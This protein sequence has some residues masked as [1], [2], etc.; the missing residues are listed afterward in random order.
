MRV[1][2]KDSSEVRSKYLVGVRSTSQEY[3]SPTK[4]TDMASGADSNN[5]QRGL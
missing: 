1:T 5:I 2:K 4:R 3:I